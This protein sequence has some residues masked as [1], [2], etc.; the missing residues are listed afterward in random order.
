[1]SFV[2]VDLEHLFV[3]ARNLNL[4]LPPRENEGL[5]LEITDAVDLDSFRVQQTYEG[6]IDLDGE[7]KALPGIPTEGKGAVEGEPDMEAL[8]VIVQTLNDLYGAD[9][10]EKDRIWVEEIIAEVEGDEGLQAIMQADNTMTNKR[11]K[12][13]EVIDRQIL[14][15]VNTSIDLFKKLTDP[16]VN[17][18]FKA[19]L[20]ERLIQLAKLGDA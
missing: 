20:F 8:S 18:A 16:K 12:V 5:P 13:D 1:M 7:A 19:R 10:T 14:G 9:L 17:K 15:Q 4:K 6:Q 11:A 2:D 3:F